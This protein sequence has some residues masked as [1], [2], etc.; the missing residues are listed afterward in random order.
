MPSVT[1][2]T[3]PNDL[4]GAVQGEYRRAGW[5][6]GSGSRRG[7]AGRGGSAGPGHGSAVV[8]GP[9]QPAWLAGG[10]LRFRRRA[11]AVGGRWRLAA[12]WARPGRGDPAVV[13]IASCHSP[14]PSRL[15]V[16]VAPVRQQASGGC[17]KENVL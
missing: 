12:A 4:V 17:L 14:V 10:V 6:R 8:G 15:W 13:A 16:G 11:V 1:A 2:C 7:R 5:L 3:A 9:G